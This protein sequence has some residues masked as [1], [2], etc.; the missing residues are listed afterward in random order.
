MNIN[1][2]EKNSVGIVFVLALT[3]VFVVLSVAVI[4]LGIGAY[5]RINNNMETNN[6]V[7]QTLLYITNKIKSADTVSDISIANEDNVTTI[8]IPVEG[9]AT[10]IY[11]YEGIL[12]EAFVFD[13][14]VFRADLGDD[15]VEIKNFAVTLQNNKLTIS[16]LSKND[17]NLKL[18]IALR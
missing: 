4:Y 7:R 10:Y 8:V 3:L 2:K 13:D 11:Y 18:D 15:L 16:V 17:K 5:R 1:N 12:K 14:D 6:E 9:G